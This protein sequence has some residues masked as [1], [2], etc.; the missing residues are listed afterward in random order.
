MKY[1]VRNWL[2]QQPAEFYEAGTHV[3]IH[4][5]NTAIERGSD[6]VEEAGMRT[7][8]AQLH[9]DVRYDCVP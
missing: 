7:C 9:L 2:H 6:Y 8:D 3:L 1:A 5:W 4:K